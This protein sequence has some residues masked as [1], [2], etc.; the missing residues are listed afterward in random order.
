[1]DVE[2]ESGALRGEVAVSDDRWGTAEPIAVP[3]WRIRCIRCKHVIAWECECR[4]WDSSDGLWAAGQE[5]G[6]IGLRVLH[7]ETCRP[8]D[9]CPRRACRQPWATP[10]KWR[11]GEGT[12]RETLRRRAKAKAK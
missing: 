4:P 10:P 12:S 9:R 3:Q 5:M 6:A 1:M 8:P 2:R 11:H 7:E